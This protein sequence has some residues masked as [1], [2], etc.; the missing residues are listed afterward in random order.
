[1]PKSKTKDCQ[2]I[3]LNKRRNRWEVTIIYKRKRYYLGSYHNKKIARAV[4]ESKRDEFYGTESVLDLRGEVWIKMDKHKGEYYVSNKGRVK[5][6]NFKGMGYE[7]LCGIIPSHGYNQVKINRES[8][9]IHR[10][11]L[12]YFKGESDLPVNHKDGNGTNNILENLEY[13]SQ[14]INGCH[15]YFVVN[16]R[17]VLTGAHWDK[18]NNSWRSEININGRLVYLGSFNTSIEA[19]DRYLRALLDYG[20]QDDYDYIVEMIGHKPHVGN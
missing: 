1:M 12:Q 6:L 4:W 7:R 2:G 17:N 11:V 13:V 10:L 18:W 20:L 3:S 5:N 16:K 9:S 19:C 14:R 8:Y 15:G